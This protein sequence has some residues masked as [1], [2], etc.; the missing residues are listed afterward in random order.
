M[1][2]VRL[3]A[4]DA[5]VYVPSF[6][7]LKQ[8][9]I[10]LNPDMR[11][12][13][14]VENVETPNGV[15]QPRAA[16]VVLGGHF[17]NRIETLLRFHR[18]Y[19]SGTG[20][21]D[22]LV[23]AAGGNL[24]QKQEGSGDWEIITL[25]DGVDAFQSNVWSW[26]TY[27]I[28]IDGADFPVDVLVI[29][30]AYDGMYIVVPSDIGRT[31]GT[32]KELTWGQVKKHT[33]NW[34]RDPQWMI[35]PVDTKGNKFGVIER[36]NERIWGGGIIGKEDY[37]YYSVAYDPMDWTAYPYPD[38]S[39]PTK[40]I[41]E[42]EDGA[43]EIMLPSWDGDKFTTLKRFGDHLIAFKQWKL[44]RIIGTN[45]G[46]YDISEQYG[47][48]APYPNTVVNNIERILIAD[49]DGMSTY[50]GMSVS[51]YLRSMVEEVWKTVNRDAMDQMYA[52][53]YKEKYY[54][55]LPV[56]DSMVNNALLIYDLR[57]GTILYHKDIYIE[58]LLATDERLYATSS[59]LP[60][61]VL[62]I[63]FDS[64]EVGAASGAPV[65]WVSPWLDFGRKDIQKGGFELYFLPEVQDTAVTL[66]FS[67][68]TEK[69]IKLKQYTVKPLTP[70]QIA[71]NRGHRGKR[72]HF[73][74]TGRRFRL[75]IETD[76]GVTAPWRLIGGLHV[77]AET[78]PD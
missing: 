75:I 40:L 73:G 49:K 42:P 74:G 22:F 14:E 45:P 23:A 56:G 31:W 52:A 34:L 46:E 78:D 7:G 16:S 9:D 35:L 67:I 39:D 59:S 61:R 19:Y 24:Y 68:Q 18:R 8:D 10:D 37:L 47:G 15:L 11:F 17:D 44:W 57:E 71:N 30:N 69:K 43:G 6:L 4:Y 64:W 38:P 26:V 76:E 63:R 70:E 66:K 27:E 3:N 41:G 1:S 5:D 65:R 12:A 58:S 32:L 36:H 51:P 60:G 48:G 29:S 33:W 72:L 28:N 2:Q 13:A 55:A 20:S 21:K 54:L 25:P 50:D 62:E 53:M 77:I